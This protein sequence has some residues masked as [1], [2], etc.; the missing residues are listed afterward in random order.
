MTA[1][2]C[3]RSPRPR[4]RRSAWCPSP[5]LHRFGRV[6]SIGWVL[7][8][9]DTSLSILVAGR[10]TGE[11]ELGRMRSTFSG[12]RWEELSEEEHRAM[13]GDWQAQV[14]RGPITAHSEEHQVSSDCGVAMLRSFWKR[15]AEAV[16][17]PS[18]S[19]PLLSPPSSSSGSG[20]D[21]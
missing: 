16:A 15:Q 13:P 3:G 18:S 8:H 10:V 20:N 9:D 21:S 14:G 12:K 17:P 6:E 4:C 5:R 11:S 1:A 19:A 7:P 2:C